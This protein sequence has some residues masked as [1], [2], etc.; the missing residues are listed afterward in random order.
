MTDRPKANEFLPRA[1]EQT[2]QL[3]QADDARQGRSERA[4]GP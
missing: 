3:P 1:E 4:E 2:I